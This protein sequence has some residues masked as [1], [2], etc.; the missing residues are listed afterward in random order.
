[1]RAY[2][3]AVPAVAAALA[4]AASA[5]F[6]EQEAIPGWVKSTAGW[7]A[8][9]SIGDAD[10]INSLQWLADAGYINLGGP[11]EP[12]YIHRD[13]YYSMEQPNGWERQ[14]PMRDPAAGSVRDSMVMAD[15]IDEPV[16]AIISVQA[17]PLTGANLT[18]HREWGLGL[19][20]EY[21]GDAFVHTSAVEAAVAG[22][23]GY[24]DRYEIA[25]FGIDILGKSY[26]FEH[27]GDVYEIKY[28][29]DIRYFQEHLPEFER[30]VQ[31]FQLA[32]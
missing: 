26:S 15:T 8:D 5:A 13:S 24:I 17:Y 19:V 27:Q 2:L 3:L 12:D 31:T 20:K 32:E 23:P 7:W 28:E 21:L 6:S 18:E 22:N 1:M 29:A 30:I 25:V 9:G 10:Y 11:G 14:I 4:L 16:P